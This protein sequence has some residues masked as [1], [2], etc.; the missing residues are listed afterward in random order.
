MLCRSAPS[1]FGRLAHVVHRAV[2]IDGEFDFGDKRKIESIL[3][4][5]PADRKK[6]AIL[7]LLHLAQQENGGYLSK[8]CLE[9]VAALTGS[10][11]G[12]VHE[13]ASFYHMFRFDK[14][15]KH[16]VEKCNGL[17]CF[18]HNGDKIKEAIEKAT[19]GTFKEGGSPDGEFDLHEVECLGAC[20]SAPV[21]I[22]D[23]V[24]YQTLKEEEIG[25]ILNKIK[26]GEDASQYSALKTRPPKPA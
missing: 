7:P 25:I 21:M 20:A 18:L 12:R 13:T 22:V 5:Y 2:L 23:G 11:F 10:A 14:P 3:G 9:K 17:S 1:V 19:G 16:L 6:S 24:Y 8:G 15:R 4:K 26:R